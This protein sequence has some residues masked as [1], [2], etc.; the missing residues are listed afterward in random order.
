MK[1]FGGKG[2]SAIV[3]KS[4]AKPAMLRLANTI[5]EISCVFRRIVTAHSVGNCPPIPLHCDHPFRNDGK[6]NLQFKIAEK[7]SG[8]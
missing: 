2:D 7:G 8:K 1:Q 4:K 3:E 6:R 5:S